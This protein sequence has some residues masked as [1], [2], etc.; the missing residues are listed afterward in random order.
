L[1]KSRNVIEQE[2]IKRLM[3]QNPGMFEGK[4]PTVSAPD[5]IHQLLDELEAGRYRP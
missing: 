3:A 2:A 1:A 4:P 5:V